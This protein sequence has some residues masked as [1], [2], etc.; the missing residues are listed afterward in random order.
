MKKKLWLVVLLAFLFGSSPVFAQLSDFQKKMMEQ[1]Q[2]KMRSGAVSTAGGGFSAQPNAPV[3]S[4]PMQTKEGKALFNN[5]SLG[6]NGKSCGTCHAEGK[7]P[8]DGSGVNNHVVAYIQYCYEHAIG[9]KKVI[10]A[11]KLE[12]IVVYIQSAGQTSPGLAPDMPNRAEP[13]QG[14]QGGSGGAAVEEDSW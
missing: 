10:A 3:S 2:Q 8:L 4:S 11:D 7:K 5:V 12:K 14:V 1:M 6:T 9:G 13:M